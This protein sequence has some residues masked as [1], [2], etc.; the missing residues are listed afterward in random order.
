MRDAAAVDALVADVFA[1]HGRLD[2]LFNNAGIAVGGEVRDLTLEDWRDAVEVN[3]MGVVHGVQAAWPRM[4]EQGFGHVVNTASMA[5]FMATA[6]AA[7]YGATKSAVVGLSRALRVEGAAHGVCASASSAPGVVRTP[8]LESGGRHGRVR[9]ASSPPELQRP[10]GSACG[11]WTRTPSRGS[12]STTWPATARSSSTPPGGASLRFLNGVAPSLMDALAPARARALPG[13]AGAVTPA[14]IYSPSMLRLGV[15]IDHVA[16]VRQARRAKEPDPV[17][18]A[19]LAE[20]GGADGITVHL[21]GDRRHIQDRDLEVLRQIVRTRLNVEMAT[22]QEMTRIALTVKP[23]QVTLVPERR[24]ELTTEGGLDVVLNSVQIRPMVKTLQEAG[25]EVSLFVDPELEQ[26]K[27]AHKLDAR[28][29]E[30]N[31]AAWSE[32]ADAAGARGG[33]AQGDRRRAPRAQ[34][35]ARRSTPGTASTTA[36]WAR[37]RRSPRSPSSTSATPSWPARCSWAWS[38]RCGRW[39]RPCGRAA[40]RRV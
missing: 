22:T 17:H 8:I 26:V 27:E 36:T 35:G 18:A 14:A 33:A 6:L 15:N 28:A 21:R 4:I 11:R 29:I 12:P 2:Y 19:V 32:A 1:R 37:S 9:A 3:L 31:T 40:R 7:P 13:A 24:E 23:D 25:I 5:A 38:G 16:T 30:I 34:A 39:P 10:S 20:L